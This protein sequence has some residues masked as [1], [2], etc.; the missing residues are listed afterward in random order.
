MKLFKLAALVIFL[1]WGLL[2]YLLHDKRDS[3]EAPRVDDSR[4]TYDGVAACLMLK[5]PR[6]YYKRYNAL[7]HNALSNIPTTWALQLFVDDTFWQKELLVYH[8]GL[9]RLLKNPR[10]KIT[11]LPDGLRNK[12]P[13][14][15]WRDRW[16]WEHVVADRVLTFNGDGVLCSNSQRSW[17][18]LVGL[19]YLGVPWSDGDGGDGTTHSVRLASS[20]LAALDYKPSGGHRRHDKFL[21]QTLQ[22]MNRDKGT[23]YQIANAEQTEWFG[24][25]RNLQYPNGTLRMDSSWGPMVVTGTQADL[26]QEARNWIMGVCPEIKAIYPSLHHPA[27]FGARPNE[28]QCAE[29]LGF[30]TCVASASTP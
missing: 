9:P 16:I 17:E 24:G 3:N 2:F 21:V 15:V 30:T 25:T 7:L 19:D 29:S 12:K 4:S 23:S 8:R 11:L 10:V 22:E 1:Q 28:T 27:C 13:N 6:W 26:S 14:V 5:R 20:M 18:D